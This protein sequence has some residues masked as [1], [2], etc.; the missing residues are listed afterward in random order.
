MMMPA[1]AATAATAMT[2]ETTATL[3]L[4]ALRSAA[5]RACS[6]VG[7][8]RAVRSRPSSRAA[9]GAATVPL[10]SVT[11]EALIA[12]PCARPEDACFALSFCALASRALR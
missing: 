2:T 10:G 3:R 9:Y 7:A 12:V 5:A 11:A 6:L 1:L 8:M 4:V